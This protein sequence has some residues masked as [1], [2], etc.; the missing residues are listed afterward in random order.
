MT[1]KAGI[2]GIGQIGSDHLR[3]LANTVS[4]VEVV[5]VCDI[6]AGKAQK[7]L[8]QHGIQAKNYN[9]Y[10]DLINDK[11]VEVVVITASNEA[12]ADVAVAA[13]KAQKYVFCEKPLAVT[14]ED[15]MRVIAAE[16]ENGRR[17]VQIGFMRRYDK[18]YVQLKNIIDS[19]EIG[20]P[21]MVHGRHYNAHTVEG[22]KTPQAIYETLIHEI[23]VMHWLLDE[24]YKTVKVYFPRQSSLV[25]T[26]RDP[27]LVVMETTSGINIVVE[28]FVNCQYGYDIHCDVSGE[29]GLAEL[30]T[31]ASAAVRKG[32]KYSTDILVD[33]KQRF[34]EAYDIEFQDFF[35]RLNAGKAPA[36][37]NSW[38]GYLA[39]VTADAC[40]KSQQTGNTE[41]IEL[42]VKPDFYK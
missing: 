2:V 40:V 27:Q 1:L 37:P 15:C 12:H 18:G 4:G 5:A 42:P 26:L 14:A 16:R 28:V 41:I 33:W 34:I 22:Y 11:E 6:V 10:H 32:A 7:A 24:D 36:G 30:P 31:V 29:K 38:D 23:D 13:L 21:L 3:R 8:D 35:D 25:N 20:Q 19:G 39:A 17:M 9:D